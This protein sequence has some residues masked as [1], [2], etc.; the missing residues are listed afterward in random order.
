M[1]GRWYIAE[2]VRK[3]TGPANLDPRWRTRR[4][5]TVAPRLTDSGN[6]VI[7]REAELEVIERAAGE[8]APHVQSAMVAAFALFFLEP[9]FAADGKRTGEVFVVITALIG[10]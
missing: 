5:H 2:S 4:T 1:R 3:R 9:R 8:A 6:L 10:P 7:A